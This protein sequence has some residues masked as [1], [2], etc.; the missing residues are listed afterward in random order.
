M[1]KAKAVQKSMSPL[2]LVVGC[3]RSGT[4]I[5]AGLLHNHGVWGGRYRPT[6]GGNPRGYFENRRIAALLR[7]WNETGE[8]PHYAFKSHIKNILR[9]EKYPGGPWFVKYGL[10][11]GWSMWKKFNPCWLLVR[12]AWN[13]VIRSQ[14]RIF[15]TARPYSEFEEINRTMD[16]IRESNGG[17]DIFPDQLVSGDYSILEK[18]LKTYANIHFNES[19]AN[20]F[21]DKGLWHAT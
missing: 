9:K 8:M 4:S 16:F 18:F 5:V 19:I 21:T 3:A 20:R 10:D 14:E 7:H 6:N 12:R 13:D 15:G 2:I 11:L 17:V 1:D